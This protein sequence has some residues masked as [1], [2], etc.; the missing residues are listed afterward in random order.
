MDLRPGIDQER[1]QLRGSLAIEIRVV[2]DRAMLVQRDDIAVRQFALGMAGRVAKNLVDGKLRQ[3]FIECCGRRDVAE[4]APPC[5]KAHAGEFVGGLR[6]AA[7]V[8]QDVNRGC[9]VNAVD[10]EGMTVVLYLANENTFLAVCGQMAGGI[11]L[12]VDD[13]NVEMRGPV[14]VRVA[15]HGMPVILGLKIDENGR[16]ARRVDD[17]GEGQSRQRRPAEEV[18]IGAERITVVIEKRV[19]RRARENDRVRRARTLQRMIVAAANFLYMSCIEAAKLRVPVAEV[20]CHGS[21]H[22]GSRWAIRV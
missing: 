6:R 15:G 18:G 12:F 9:R 14:A 8:M 4:D 11:F 20:Q 22:T 21:N 13:S 3:A 5:R 19:F 17:V 7:R 16:L 1:A 10:A 2:Q